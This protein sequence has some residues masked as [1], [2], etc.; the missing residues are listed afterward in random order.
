MA[1]KEVRK[2][3]NNNKK[4]KIYLTVVD[5]RHLMDFLTLPSVGLQS[6]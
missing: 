4:K 1:H 6:A 5:G 3:E 2:A